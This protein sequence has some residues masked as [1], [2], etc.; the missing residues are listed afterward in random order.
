[1]DCNHRSFP[2]VHHGQHRSIFGRPD[3][4]PR[5]G[6]GRARGQPRWRHGSHPAVAGTQATAAGLH[7]AT[8]S[9]Q[10]TFLDQQAFKLYQTNAYYFQSMCRNSDDT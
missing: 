6:R 5:W 9:A 1:L 4:P 3:G 10:A 2:S 8:A 7:H